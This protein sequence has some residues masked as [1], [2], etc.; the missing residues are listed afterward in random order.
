MGLRNI[1]GQWLV[2]GEPGTAWPVGF[3]TIF[4]AAFNGG[5]VPYYIQVRLADTT[6]SIAGWA[7]FHIVQAPTE[8]KN[9]AT[10][11]IAIGK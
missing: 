9:A 11:I 7:R 3:N 2:S 1:I 10:E 4:R 5:S 8:A 6:T